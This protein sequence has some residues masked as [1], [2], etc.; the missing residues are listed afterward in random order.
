MNT[1]S[2][3][4]AGASRPAVAVAIAAAL[5]AATV[6]AQTRIVNISPVHVDYGE[7]KVGARI[8]V[9]VTIDNLTSEELQ[10]AGGGISDSEEITGIGGTC[11]GGILPANG[12]CAINYYFKPSAAGQSFTASTMIAVGAQ[13]VGSTSQALTFEGTGTES[14][15]QVSPV[16]ID[17]GTQQIGAAVTVPVTF[18]NTHY[19]TVQL[20]G[21]GGVEAPFSSNGGDCNGGVLP[22]ATAC[23]FNYRFT[24]SSVDPAEDSTGVGISAPPNI[25]ETYAFNFEGAGATSSGIVTVVPSGI[26]F[27]E[28]KIGTTAIFP[29]IVTNISSQTVSFAGGGFNDNAGGAFGGSTNCGGGLDPGEQCHFNYRFQPRVLGSVSATTSIAAV[30]GE[31]SQGFPLHFSGTGIGTLARV[32]PVDIDFG[33][34]MT[35]TYMIVPVTVTNTSEAPLTG[36]VGGDVSYPF[37][38][39]NHCPASLDVGDSCTIDYRFQ[40]SISALGRRSASTILSFTNDTGVR[41]NVTITM[42]GT[43]YDP[44]LLFS[45]GF[46]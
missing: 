18:T 16:A 1:D 32:T 26:D 43:S 13:G 45:D 8:L 46:D 33:Q 4:Y 23:H 21:G 5:F 41:P 30:A 37:S 36:F 39:T 12:S 14:L 40:S 28:I 9:P 31:E 3:Q 6:G 11:N 10:I 20:A 7:I 35:G 25:Y 34:V 29:V 42:S 15:V 19:E 2:V 24:A 38:A 44:E 22:A 27:G 17:F